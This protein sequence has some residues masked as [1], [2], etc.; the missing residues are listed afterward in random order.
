MAERPGGK[1]AHGGKKPSW[2]D[3]GHTAGV[4]LWLGGPRSRQGCRFECLISSEV[5][6]GAIGGRFRFV[7]VSGQCFPRNLLCWK[8]AKQLCS[9]ALGWLV[10]QTQNTSK[11]L[12]RTT[13]ATAL[14]PPLPMQLLQ[15]EQDLVCHLK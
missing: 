11:G 4:S 5:F 8:T 7:F 1:V 12:L 13:A 9:E 14:S 2:L 10:C 15:T 3:W 6:D